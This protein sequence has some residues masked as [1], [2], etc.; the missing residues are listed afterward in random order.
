MTIVERIM[1]AKQKKIKQFPVNSNRASDLGQP[2]VKYHVLNRTKWQER[3]LHGP[4]LQAVFDLGNEYEKIIMGELAEAGIQVIEQQ[5]PFE[6]RE[7]QITGHIDGKLLVD[8]EIVPFDAKSCSPFVFDYINDINSLKRG[9]YPY[10]RNI[11]HSSNLYMLM[12]IMNEGCCCLRT[13]SVVYI[14]RFGWT[15]TTSSERKRY[16]APR[17]LIDTL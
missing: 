17:Q 4:E 5:R 8:G 6:W 7:Y 12:S 10:L 9:K 11:L 2:C 3:E 15:L 16:S 1:A 13:R 14:R